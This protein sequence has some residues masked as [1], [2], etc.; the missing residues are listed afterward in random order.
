MRHI[1]K[2]LMAH[3]DSRLKSTTRKLAAERHSYKLA[4]P[5]AAIDLASE[6]E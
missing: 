2:K 3:V 1:V 4:A 5:C 6:T